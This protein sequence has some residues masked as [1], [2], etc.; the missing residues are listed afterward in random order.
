MVQT[1]PKIK[2]QLSKMV[3]PHFNRMW[4]T[5]KPYIICNGGRGSFK[6]STVSLKIV[7]MM[8][9]YTQQGKTV[10][11]I[12][13][14]ENKAYLRDS[15]YNQ[16]AWALNLL[17]LQDEYRF[18]TSPLRI[19]HK[20]TKSTFYFYGSDD[21]MKLKSNIVG[22]VVAV[23]Y[24]EAANMKSP[25]VF[26][27]ANPSF[28]RQK[29]DFVDQVKVFWTYN[30]PKNPY[31]WINEWVA[32]MMANDEYLVDTSTYLD[33]ELGFTTE[34]Q[35]KLIESYKEN[36]YDYYRW[37]YLSEVIG[38]GNNVYNMNLFHKLDGL[39]DDWNIIA[40]FY[41]M[42][43]GHQVSATTVTHYGL[44]SNQNVV[45]LDTYY[46]SPQGRV[47]K[48]APSEFSTEVYEFIDETNRVYRSPIRNQTI[49]SAEGGFRNQYWLDHHTRWHP[50]AKQKK[51]NMI[52]YAQDLLAQ[53]RFY[54]L[55]KSD[56]NIFV[57]QHQQYR[58]DED[59][60]SRDNPEVIKE[61]DHTCD[62]FQYFCVDNARALG[63]K[64]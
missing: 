34:Q 43:V 20:K 59:T 22:N 19:V 53:G 3:N 11:A 25:D 24:E 2:I 7:T 38:L 10:N 36:D 63:L 37:L 40:E 5:P 50:I 31:D 58:W 51:V 44:C 47:N 21:P 14:R 49:D 48:K 54:Y 45:L 28:I 41:S 33:D 61:N 8:K 35:L 29:P 55:N 62:A 46:Y 64:R 18:Y 6:S 60:V 30:P 39:P 32:K 4:N 9:K 56:N 23:W 12:C 1:K 17:G 52:D 15:V 26:D 42:D 57:E 27:Q 13:I 16:V